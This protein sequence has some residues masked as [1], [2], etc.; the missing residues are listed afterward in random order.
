MVDAC[1][2]DM[3]SLFERAFDVEREASIDFSRD[4]SGNDL[5]NLLSEFDKQAV[6][7]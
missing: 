7:C 4:L 3:K 6:Q 5:K 1:I 2:D